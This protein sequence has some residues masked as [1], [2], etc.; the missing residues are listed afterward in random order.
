MLVAIFR[1]GRAKKEERRAIFRLIGE[2]TRHS[3][4]SLRCHPPTGVAGRTISRL[5]PS[6]SAENE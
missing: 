5:S 6:T 4:F 3:L 2:Q 1:P